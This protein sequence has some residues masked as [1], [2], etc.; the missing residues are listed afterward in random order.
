MRRHDR[1]A[2]ALNDSVE[3]FVERLPVEAPPLSRIT[4]VKIQQVPCNGEIEFRILAS[5][6]GEAVHTLISP[7][8]ATCPDCLR[9]MLDPRDGRYRYPFIN[10]TNCGPRF[11]I[12]HDIPYDRPS[13]SMSVFPMCPACQKE[14]DDPRDRRFHA[15][16]NACWSCG[17]RVELWDRKGRRIGVHDPVAEAAADCKQGW[18]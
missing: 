12:V 8:V 14:Y 16:P 17:P 13:T 3:D 5:R 6:G 18:W 15:Q 11:T 1:S 7:D 9:E 10:C 2:G 4:D